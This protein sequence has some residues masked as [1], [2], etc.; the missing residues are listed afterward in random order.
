MF[1]KTL[2]EQELDVYDTANLAVW[3]SV[4]QDHNVLQPIPIT[5]AFCVFLLNAQKHLKICLNEESLK[6]NLK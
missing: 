4:F 3:K 6:K 2:K 5:I 1:I